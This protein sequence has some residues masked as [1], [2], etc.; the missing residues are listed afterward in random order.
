M[1]AVRWRPL[2]PRQVRIRALRDAV[3]EEL[4]L[5]PEHDPVARA[6][7]RAVRALVTAGRLAGD[8]PVPD[9]EPER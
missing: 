9:R 7:R 3:D 1:T 6:L 5:W 2:S 8:L 4:S